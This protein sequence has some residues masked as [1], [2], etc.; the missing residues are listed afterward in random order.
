[1]PCIVSVPTKHGDL[2]QNYVKVY[3]ERIPFDYPS[4]I[5]L[6]S[7]NHF[8]WWLIYQSRWINYKWAIF[9][10]FMWFIHV[11]SDVNSCQLL[12]SGCRFCL[13]CPRIDL[14]RDP[15]D[16]NMVRCHVGLS[17]RNIIYYMYIWI[18]IY[19]YIHTYIHIYIYIH[20][21]TLISI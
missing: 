20:I 21:H 2:N 14:I 15:R 8:N 19:T 12:I 11:M 1:M 7:L 6:S 9:N 3:Q 16:I 10:G 17:K 4:I 18:Y 5:P 13:L